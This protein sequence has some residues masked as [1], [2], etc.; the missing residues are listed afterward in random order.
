MTT[1]NLTAVAVLSLLKKRQAAQ[2]RQGEPESPSHRF[3]LPAPAALLRTFHFFMKHSQNIYLVPTPTC[4]SLAMGETTSLFQTLPPSHTLPSYLQHVLGSESQEKKTK[5]NPKNKTK[6]GN[7]KK[8][9]KRWKKGGGTGKGKKVHKE[10][11]PK[12]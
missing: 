5:P 11:T 9:K 6:K 12:Q 2:H 4:L 8:R 1:T 10:K 3:M 7:R